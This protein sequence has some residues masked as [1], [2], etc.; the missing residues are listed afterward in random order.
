[1][2][3]NLS[4]CSFDYTHINL[5]QRIIPPLDGCNPKQNFW[6]KSQRLI[7]SLWLSPLLFISRKHF[8]WNLYGTSIYEVKI[9]KMAKSVMNVVLY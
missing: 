4:P 7:K 8:L 1:M 3:M 5:V 2:D 9:K 6:R